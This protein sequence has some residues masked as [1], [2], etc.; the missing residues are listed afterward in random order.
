[1]SL[2]ERIVAKKDDDDGSKPVSEVLKGRKSHQMIHK[3]VF[4][5]LPILQQ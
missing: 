2:P 5:G 1:M 4:F 3:T